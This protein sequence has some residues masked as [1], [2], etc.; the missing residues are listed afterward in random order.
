MKQLS[1]VDFFRRFFSSENY[2]EWNSE[3]F[4]F[5]KWFRT[6]FRGFSH[7]KM[8]QNG[9]PRVF[10]FRETVRNGI[11][12]VFLLR[13]MVQNGIPRGLLFR[14][15]VQNGIPRFFSSAKQAEF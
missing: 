6:E 9:I 12:R 11:L 2:S 8:V 10:L 4:F 3:V 15:M 5:Q 14:E 13:E 1:K 7:P